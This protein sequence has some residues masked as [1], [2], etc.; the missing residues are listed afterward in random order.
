M[1]GPNEQQVKGQWKQFKGRIQEA[2]GDLTGDELDQYRGK[3][4]QLEG[5]LQKK[6]GEK[7]EKIRERIDQAATK[8][9]YEF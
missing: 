7:R 4:D 3:R 9:S 5:Y 1:A 8:T 2:W 6:T